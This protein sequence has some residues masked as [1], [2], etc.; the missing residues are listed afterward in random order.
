[1]ITGDREYE[2][3]RMEEMKVCRFLENMY[4]RALIKLHAKQA[5]RILLQYWEVF[6]GEGQS[7]SLL[8]LIPKLSRAKSD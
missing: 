5:S 7:G 2:F 1:M 6:L 8:N 4:L 3:V